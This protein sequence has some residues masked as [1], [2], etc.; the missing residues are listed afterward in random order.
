MRFDR[1]LES[2]DKSGKLHRNGNFFPGLE[3]KSNRHKQKISGKHHASRLSLL[4]AFVS[5][6]W[7]GTRL[8]ERTP[9]GPFYGL[10]T[11]ANRSGAKIARQRLLAPGFGFYGRVFGEGERTSLKGTCLRS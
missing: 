1:V 9:Q 10:S 6:V 7:R 8:S 5:L 3:R 2:E 4:M 11:L